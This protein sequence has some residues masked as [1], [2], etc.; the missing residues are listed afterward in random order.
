[1]VAVIATRTSYISAF[2]AGANF[3][4]MWSTT[5]FQIRAVAIENAEIN[6]A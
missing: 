6:A 2:C 4:M 5:S 1:M 3:S